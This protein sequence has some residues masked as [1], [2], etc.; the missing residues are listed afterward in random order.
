MFHGNTTWTGWQSKHGAPFPSA[1]VFFWVGSNSCERETNAY[2]SHGS[3]VFRWERPILM[4]PVAPLWGVLRWTPPAFFLVRAPTTGTACCASTASRAR[5]A[6]RALSWRRPE[7]RAV[8]AE[9]RSPW[10]AGRSKVNA[11]V[12]KGKT[13]QRAICFLRL[14]LGSKL[15]GSTGL[16]GF[17]THL[18][19][20]RPPMV[21]TPPNSEGRV[22][23]PDPR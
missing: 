6:A 3:D 15:M 10:G 2:E 17:E 8:G 23:F 9:P 1:V 19:C 21:K 5:T 22:F 18:F 7:R 4:S 11:L 20:Q 14:S 12:V 16:D 13:R